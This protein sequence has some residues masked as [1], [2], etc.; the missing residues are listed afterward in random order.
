M[1]ELRIFVGNVPIFALVDFVGVGIVIAVLQRKGYFFRPVVL[2]RVLVLLIGGL[3]ITNAS[4]FFWTRELVLAH[5]RL[6]SIAVMMLAYVAKLAIFTW[7]LRLP[8]VA[9]P[10]AKKKTVSFQG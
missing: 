3:A 7:I 5:E 8:P 6:S 9:P 4:A 1:D 10:D 2:L